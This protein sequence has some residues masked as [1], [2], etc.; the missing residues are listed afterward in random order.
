[1][2][3]QGGSLPEPCD[4]DA[5]DEIPSANQGLLLRVKVEASLRT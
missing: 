5:I 2:V 3:E 4:R 1:M